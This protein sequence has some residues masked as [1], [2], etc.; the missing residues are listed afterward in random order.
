LEKNKT[1]HVNANFP[2]YIKIRTQLDFS[3]AFGTCGP[4]HLIFSEISLLVDIN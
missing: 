4:S 2:L 3:L 1:L